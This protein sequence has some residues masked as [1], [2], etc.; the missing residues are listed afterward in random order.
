MMDETSLLNR[1]YAAFNARDIDGVLAHTHADIDWPNGWEGG[2]LHGTAAVRDYWTRQWAEIDP[3]VTP[4]A[5]T[6]RPDGGIAVTV[7]QVVRTH[8]GAVQS[9]S[10]VIHVYRFEAGRVRAMDILPSG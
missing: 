6:T 10:R 3:V 7:H 1:L 5:F 2:R 8:D 9:D 4:E